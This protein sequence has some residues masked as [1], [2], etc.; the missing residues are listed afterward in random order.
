MKVLWIL[1]TPLP[2]AISLQTGRPDVSHSTG[3]WVHAMARLLE[4][5]PGLE[6]SVAAPARVEKAIILRGKAITHYLLPTR[7]QDWEWLR[8]QVQPDLIHIHGTEYPCFLEWVKTCGNSHTVVSLQGL[9]SRIADKYFGGIPEE[10]LRQYVS[11]RDRI[12]KDSLFDQKKN[13]VYRGSCEIELLKSVNHVIGRTAW[14]RSNALEI[15]PNLQYH[16]L[17]EPLREPFYSGRWKYDEC[18]PFRIF[19]TQAHYPLKGLHT[20][21]EALPSVLKKAPDVSVHIAGPDILRGTGLRGL[22]LRSG[23]GRFIA[24]MIHEKGLEGRIQFIG[25]SDAGTVKHE[26]MQAN[27]FLSPSAIENSSNALCEAQILGVPVIAT[28]VGGTPDLIPDADHG[29]LYE[30]NDTA[31]LTD[32]I[33]STFADSCRFDASSMIRTAVKRHDRQT[34]LRDLLKIYD[35]VAG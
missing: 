13:L 30:F 24:D 17:S 4:Q 22:L 6:L 35:E 15:N 5:I 20:F 26:L 2:E 27:L 8:E 10:T 21:L 9:V 33:L 19:M 25:E 11:L 18:V 7:K 14:D 29:R 31:A 3:S 16:T 12:R 34:I 23:Y 32:A 28:A 1:N